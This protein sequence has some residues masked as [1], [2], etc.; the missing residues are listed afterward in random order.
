MQ[1]TLRTIG[2]SYLSEQGYKRFVQLHADGS[3]VKPDDCGHVIAAL[4]VQAS[5]SLTGQ[6]VTWNSKECEPYRNT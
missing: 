5:K 2:D 1:V 3:L 6:F 4:S